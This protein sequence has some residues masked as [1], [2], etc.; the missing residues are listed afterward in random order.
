MGGVGGVRGH[1]GVG[2]RAQEAGLNR[3][4][5]FGWN[6]DLRRETHDASHGGQT[7][8]AGSSFCFTL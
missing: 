1:V 6:R 5:G 3:Y 2:H 8:S 4:H 7:V